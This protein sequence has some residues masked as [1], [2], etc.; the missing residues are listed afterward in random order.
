MKRFSAG[1]MMQGVFGV[2]FGVCLH[3]QAAGAGA[4]RNA[5]DLWMEYAK[6]L[7]FQTNYAVDME[8][9]CMGMVMQSHMACRDELSRVEMMM[10]MT[11]LRMVTLNL[12]E[13]GRQV[14]YAMFPEKKVY[15]VLPESTDGAA[16][17]DKGVKPVI[18]DAGTEVF[19]GERC[20]RRRITVKDPDGTV[21]VMTLLSAPSKK[22]MP[23]KI[24]SL[25]TPAKADAEMGPITSTMLYKNYDFSIPAASL[26]VVPKDYRR[27]ADMQTILMGSMM[28]GA[29]VSGMPS[30]AQ[31][32][33]MM[34]EAQRDA[35]KAK[36]D[37]QD[38]GEAVEQD[39][40]DGVRSGVRQGVDEAIGAGLRGLF[41]R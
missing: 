21:V 26:F 36:D 29:G 32:D 25:V 1:R 11:N 10:P 30:Q 9:Q 6:E 31:I 20:T 2:V 14:S 34:A 17:S 8:I 38:L 18:E 7:G 23:V 40:K 28:P 12:R 41:G 16:P 33:A 5:A 39:M 13:N 3:V 27:E 15:C 24:V 22:N 4:D 37:E 19:D 35:A